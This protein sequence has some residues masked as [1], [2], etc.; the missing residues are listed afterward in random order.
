MRTRPASLAP[1]L[2]AL[3]LVPVAASAHEVRPAYLQIVERREGGLSVLWKQPAMGDVGLRL[4]PRLASGLLDGPPAET[5]SSSAFVVKRW[6]DP[7]HQAT[8]RGER[9]TVEGLEASLTDVLLDVT[10]ADGTTLQHV[11]KPRSPSYAFGGSRGSLAVPAY[12]RLG[13][14]HILTGFDHLLFVLGLLLLVDG[15]ARLAKTITAFTVAH[16]IT[17]TCAAVGLVRLDAATVEAVIALSL[18]FVGVELVR[19]AH[20]R[21][22]LTARRPWLVAFSFGLLHGFAFARA[23]ADVGL[24]KEH[25]PLSLLLFNTGVEIGQL[26]FVAAAYAVIALGRRLHVQWPARGRLVAPYAIASFAS[27]WL[28]E[29]LVKAVA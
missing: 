2:A 11:L 18:V 17:L 27:F 23:L 21:A 13:V 24:P 25:V 12:V 10:Y 3:A 5:S 7:T 9:V 29:R 22:G 16:S 1:V 8:L 6:E 19:K 20:G 4:V 15:R 28:I 26:L 14:E